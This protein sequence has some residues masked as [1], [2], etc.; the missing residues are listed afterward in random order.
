[1]MGDWGSNGNW[2]IYKEE[3]KVMEEVMEEVIEVKKLSILER[4]R[5]SLK[6]SGVFG[7]VVGARLGG[8]STLAGTLS[9]K[10]AMLQAELFETGSGSAIAKAKELGNHLDVYTFG[11]VSELLELVGE[12]AH[13]DYD[14]I[15]ID[16]STGITEQLYR[17]ADISA[18]IKKN[19]WDGFRIVSDEVERVMLTTK[20]LTEEFGKNVF[21]TLSVAEKYDTLGNLIEIKAEQKGN[22]VVKNIRAIFPVVVAL[23]SRFDEEGNQL[24]EP[25][26]VT[27]TDGLYAARIDSILAK[28][29]PGII[30]PAN[31]AKIIKLSKGETKT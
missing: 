7:V 2:E 26:L 1:M 3:D 13:S 10:T 18:A 31:L 12:L 5:L 8:K 11:N 15:Y 30:Y 28:Q 20:Q 23:R 6:K 4:K 19:T 25:E 17:K 29:N 16:G 21:F 9:G 27:K 24:D 22:A 14:N